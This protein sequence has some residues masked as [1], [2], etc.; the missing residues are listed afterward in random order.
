MSDGSRVSRSANDFAEGA[1][2]CPFA[3]V[4]DPASPADTVVAMATGASAALRGRSPRPHAANAA[5]SQS[6][7]RS[8]H[9][10]V[11]GYFS[12]A[13]LAWRL[14]TIRADFRQ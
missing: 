13:W 11:R 4:V 3:S 2:F 5:A 6:P 1:I 10:V 14:F 12:M 8:L 9:T 7:E